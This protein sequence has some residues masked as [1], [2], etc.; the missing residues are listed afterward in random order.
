[1]CPNCASAM[2]ATDDAAQEQTAVTEAT[3][4][5][6]QEQ[7]PEKPFER[8]CP[9]ASSR[10]HEKKRSWGCLKFFFIMLVVTACLAAIAYEAYQYHIQ[11]QA[12]LDSLRHELARRIEEDKKKN[13]RGFQEARQD[14]ILW[15]K[16]LSA[17]TMEAA[18]EYIAA[19]PEGIFI[20]EAYLL[21]EE[22][23]RR[24][25]NPVE[26]AHIKGI[27]ENSLLQIRERYIKNKNN[28]IKDRQYH[29]PDS[30]LISKKYINRD[31]FI[32]TIHVRVE[33]ITIPTG[34]TRQDTVNID[35][36]MTLDKHKN[37]IESS[38]TAPD[39]R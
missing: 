36:H 17:K 30:L 27:V 7:E 18:H 23:Q 25:V 26:Q 3:D 9:T 4:I 14:S 37:V 13:E 15:Q 20:D 10:K 24:H 35:L 11:Q 28:R 16:T 34:K 29:L 32:Y 33:Q 6:P 22:L 5:T 1:M 8:P 12:Q 19:Y 21:L 38:L 31:S 2:P 39:K